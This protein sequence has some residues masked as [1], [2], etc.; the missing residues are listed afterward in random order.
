MSGSLPSNL[1]TVGNREFSF[2]LYESLKTGTFVSNTDM[3]TYSKMVTYLRPAVVATIAFC[4]YFQC[5]N[6]KHFVTPKQN[7]NM[8]FYTR[9]TM[10]THENIQYVHVSESSY[11]MI[12]IATFLI[13]FISIYNC[14]CITIIITII[15]NN[16]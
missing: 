6:F 5:G 13:I 3:V 7:K 12:Y 15:N 10:I 16:I 11:W 4:R 2:I 9:I 8:T 14:I 1:L